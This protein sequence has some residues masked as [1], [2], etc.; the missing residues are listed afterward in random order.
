[1]KDDSF[2]MRLGRYRRVYVPLLYGVTLLLLAPVHGIFSEWTGVMEY[3]SGK[4]LISGGGYHGW[5]SHFYPPLFSLLMGLGG[6]LG[7]G[8]LAGKVIS[9]LSASLLLLIAYELASELSTHEHVGI[10]TQIYLAFSPLYIQESLQSDNHMLD[11]LL[12]NSGLLFFLRSI[13]EPRAGRLFLAGAICACAALTRYTSYVLVLLPLSL[14]PFHNL[15]KA[16]TCTASF[17]AGFAVISSPWWYYNA[18]YNG[19]PIHNWNYLNVSVGVFGRDTNSLQFLWRW[20]GDQNIRGFKDII[21]HHTA[22]H[23]H[24][25]VSNIPL[26]VSLLI[27]SAGALALLVVP[28]V[29]ESLFS[30][31]LNQSLATFGVLAA[32]I[33]MVSQAYLNSYY[34]LSWIVLVV[35]VSAAFLLGYLRRL[36]GKFISFHTIHGGGLAMGLVLICGALMCTR[37]LREYHNEPASYRSLVDAEEITLALKAHDPKIA[38]KVIM[39]LDPA[40]AYY[41]G[42]K[43]LATPFEYTGSVDGLVHYKNVSARLRHYAPKYPSDMDES[44]LRADYLVYTRAHEDRYWELHDPPQFSF[45]LDPTSGKIPENFQLVYQSANAVVYEVAWESPDPSAK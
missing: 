21:V 3:F 28:G 36:E 22:A 11:A 40:R 45:L 13:K 42:A 15:K 35:A 4:E 17:L 19:S 24:N 12:F 18:K 8:F 33:L 34:L 7:S 30:F 29:L 5:A 20:A 32:S 23:I 2:M 1:M 27:G 16:A 31:K 41:A 14:V 39:S 10:W 26:S 38:S 43:Y 44:N 37:V 25:I 6:L 9:I